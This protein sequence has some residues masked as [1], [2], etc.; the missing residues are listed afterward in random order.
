MKIINLKYVY[1]VYF[2][3]HHRFIYLDLFI[4]HTEKD[5]SLKIHL[6]FAVL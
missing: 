2:V 1:I 4:S 6:S 5:L 3:F